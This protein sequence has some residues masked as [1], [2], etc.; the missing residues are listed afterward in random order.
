M[1]ADTGCSVGLAILNNQIGEIEL[2]QKIDDDPYEIA[3]ADGHVIEAEI[4]KTDLDLNG[5]T[6]PV[7]IYVLNPNKFKNETEEKEA[8]AYLG[9]GFLDNFNVIFKGQEKKVVFFHP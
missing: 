1:L 8:V 9:R 6:K 2:G 7:I 5:V 4:Y 3:V